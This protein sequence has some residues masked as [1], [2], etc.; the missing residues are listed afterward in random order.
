MK[1][2]TTDR[3]PKGPVCLSPIHKSFQLW[4]SVR[5]SLPP[6]H[7]NMLLP[8]SFFKAHLLTVPASPYFVVQ[9]PG[10]RMVSTLFVVGSV[11]IDHLH[12]CMEGKDMPQAQCSE[13]H[14]IH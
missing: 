12:D 13:R 7:H 3:D 14:P 8:R 9:L 4:G 5:S 10:G 2:I 6:Q 1:P 11:N